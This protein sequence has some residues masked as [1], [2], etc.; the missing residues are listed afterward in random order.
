MAPPP[1]LLL[2]EGTGES[3]SPPRDATK[4]PHSDLRRKIYEKLVKAG[5]QGGLDDSSFREMLYNH[6]DK[7]P[8]RYLIDLG[9]KKAEDVLLHRSVLQECALP[10][11]SGAVIRARFLE[12][13]RIARAQI[14]SLINAK[15]WKTSLW[16]R[17]M[18][19]ITRALCLPRQGIQTINLFMRSS[20]LA[21][22]GLNSL[23][24]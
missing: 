24:S 10:G 12:I 15:S 6:F 19:L 1:L 22:T 11:S 3:S 13:N 2:E 17:N 20:S 4:S 7:L 8:R 16:R 23:V 21:S 18:V 9:E 5:K 14:L